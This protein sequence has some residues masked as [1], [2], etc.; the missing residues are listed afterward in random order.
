MKQTHTFK[1]SVEVDDKDGRVIAVFFRVREGRPARAREFA[2][3]AAFA[4]YNNRGELLG[5]EL[6]SPC[7]ITVL[8]KIVGKDSAVRKFVRN[9]IPNAMLAA[10]A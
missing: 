5:I 2:N 1:L 8:D 9:T 4:H 6:L 3:G 7:Q 10:A